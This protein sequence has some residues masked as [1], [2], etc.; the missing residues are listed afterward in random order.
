MPAELSHKREQVQQIGRFTSL[1]LLKGTTPVPRI[2]VGCKGEPGRHWKENL[3]G[4]EQRLLE[5]AW[6][7][8]EGVLA[9]AR[10]EA[11]RG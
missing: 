2:K 8:L 7:P 6:A 4:Q 11:V 9:R 10:T 1:C 3:Q 5:G